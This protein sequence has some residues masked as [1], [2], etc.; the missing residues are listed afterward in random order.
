MRVA[1]PT[2]KLRI[3]SV[4]IRRLSIN[5]AP[6]RAEPHNARPVSLP[7]YDCEALGLCDHPAVGVGAGDSDEQVSMA[8]ALASP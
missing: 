1:L 7:G 4:M 3:S 6:Q 2:P 8:S 5:V